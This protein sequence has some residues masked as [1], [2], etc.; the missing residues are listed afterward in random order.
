LSLSPLEEIEEI[1]ETLAPL[2]KQALN[3]LYITRA[4]M[5]ALELKP[6][7]SQMPLFHKAN[8]EL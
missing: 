7:G 3:W 5:T 1:E 4:S 8:F 2:Y 6:S